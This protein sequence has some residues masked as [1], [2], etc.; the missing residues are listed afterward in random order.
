MAAQDR[1]GPAYTGVAVLALCLLGSTAPNMGTCAQSEVVFRRETGHVDPNEWSVG[2]FKTRDQ[3]LPT[4]LLIFDG[5]TVVLS[6][7][8]AARL[9]GAKEQLF[10]IQGND[11][12]WAIA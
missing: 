5:D 12:V 11:S 6:R 10:G 7:G 9:A 4:F 1:V 2:C 3:L 8:A